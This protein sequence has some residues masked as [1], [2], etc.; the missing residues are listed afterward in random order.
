MT[1]WL[2]RGLQPRTRF[3]VV[4]EWLDNGLQNRS[5]RFDPGSR[6]QISQKLDRVYLTCY[7]CFSSPKLG[8]FF[9]P[10]P[11]QASAVAGGGLC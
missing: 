6:L 10:P 1:E 3:G 9:V 4:V 11:P 8:G 7:H 5:P 2:G